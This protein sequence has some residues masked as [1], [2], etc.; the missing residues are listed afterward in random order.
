MAK[1][2]FDAE[3]LQRE[4]A[5]ER[6]RLSEATNKV[7]VLKSKL[8]SIE[9]PKRANASCDPP[10]APGGLVVTS[11]LCRRMSRATGRVCHGASFRVSCELPL[12][13]VRAQR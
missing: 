13:E 12:E 3:N 8:D 5:Q 4:V 2:M 9:N 10:A 6:T 11:Q 1:M 7:E